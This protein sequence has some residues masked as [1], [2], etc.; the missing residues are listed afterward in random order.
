[1][2]K[3]R[4]YSLAVLTEYPTANDAIVDG[5]AAV[6]KGA[7]S[8]QLLTFVD[9]NLINVTEI[10]RA[11]N[12]ETGTHGRY[13]PKDIKLAKLPK[14]SEI[15]TSRLFLAVLTE[16][17]TAGAAVTAGH[18]A[19]ANGAASAQL[20]TFIDDVLSSVMSIKERSPGDLRLLEALSQVDAAVPFGPSVQDLAAAAVAPLPSPSPFW[21]SVR[22]LAAMRDV[23]AER[24]AMSN[25]RQ[26][27]MRENFGKPPSISLTRLADLD[28]KD[29]LS[30]DE[31]LEIASAL[32]TL[33]RIATAAVSF[34][35]ATTAGAQQD[36]ARSIVD[37][38]LLVG[39]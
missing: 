14:R 10:I 13:L 36:A 12:L 37:G 22:E 26:A 29:D 3:K 27:S 18:E 24:R 33:L 11:L 8:A 20:L 16:H 30:E 31:L 38:S 39:K 35:E 28:A 7:E 1:M 25:M 9:D 6:A 21:Q 5:H 19:R 17:P 32:T 2:T 15:Q 23:P 4:S 34:R